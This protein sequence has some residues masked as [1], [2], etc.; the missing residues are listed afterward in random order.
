MRRVGALLRWVAW[1]VHAHFAEDSGH[2]VAR[3]LLPADRYV[4]LNPTGGSG[5]MDLLETRPAHLA[6]AA[7][8]VDAYLCGPAAQHALRTAAGLLN[9]GTRR[10]GATYAVSQ[11]Q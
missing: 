5:D 1:L 4:R 7:R 8:L 9:A 2:E 3:R 10:G 11:R 6:R